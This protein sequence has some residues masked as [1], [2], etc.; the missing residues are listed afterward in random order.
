MIAGID[1]Q[2]EGDKYIRTIVIGIRAMNGGVI[3]LRSVV[4]VLPCWPSGQEQS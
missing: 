2:R 3:I 4:S 1:I